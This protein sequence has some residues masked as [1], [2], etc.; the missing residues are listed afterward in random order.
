MKVKRTPRSLLLAGLLLFTTTHAAIVPVD[1]YVLRV[2]DGETTSGNRPV[3]ILQYSSDGTTASLLNTWTAPHVDAADR[4]TKSFTATTYFAL[5]RSVDGS[6]LVFSGNDAAPGGTSAGTVIGTF[7]LPN[8][9]FDTTTRLPGVNEVRAADSVDGS[10]FWYTGQVGGVW[11]V[12]YGGATGTLVSDVTHEYSVVKI[13]DNQ[14]WFTRRAA[15]TRGLYFMNVEGLP[16]TGPNPRV[17]LAAAAQGGTGWNL[18]GGGYQDFEILNENILFISN[19]SSIEVFHRSD[20]AS[21]AWHLLTDLDQALT[22]LAGATHLS[23]YELG[24]AVQV[25]YTTG[26]GTTSS[27]FWSATWDP[28]ARIFDTPV[29]LADAD[30]GYTFGGVV[31]VPEPAAYGVLLGALALALLMRRRRR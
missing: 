19:G 9:T 25:Y 26:L 14:L 10:G 8:Q 17:N 18:G 27:S 6:L 30:A 28:N 20:T 3:S 23:L 7:S 12:P 5:N 13:Q 31:V 29:K 11:H 1:V 24:H 4:I 22:G 21:N 15:T 2:G 16:T